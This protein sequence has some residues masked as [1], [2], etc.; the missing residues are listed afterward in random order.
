MPLIA[1]F[2]FALSTLTGSWSIDPAR[3]SVRFTV[4]KFGSEVVEGRF[5]DFRG[6]VVYDAKNPE[7]NA[8]Q[9]RVLVSSVETG[10][11]ARDQTLRG[12]SFFDAARFPELTFVADRIRPLPDGR[13]HVSGRITIRGRA[14]PLIITARPAGANRFVT[15]FQLDRHDFGVSGGSVSRHGISDLVTV[16]LTMTVVRP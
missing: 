8:L 5:R 4:T 3:S 13:M 14:R 11:T 2:L 12:P 1:S 15:T 10:E 7:R 9:W 16:N 6:A